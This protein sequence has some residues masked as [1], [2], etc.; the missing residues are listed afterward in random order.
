M[1]NR[2][3]DIPSMDSV[4]ETAAEFLRAQEVKTPASIDELR[5]SNESAGA[6]VEQILGSFDRLHGTKEES[7][8]ADEGPTPE[9]Y[10]AWV[11][12]MLDLEAAFLE[13]GD[14]AL[15]RQ[16]IDLAGISDA[17]FANRKDEARRLLQQSS[18]I[19]LR[20]YPSVHRL[21]TLGFAPDRFEAVEKLSVGDLVRQER[22][23]GVS[24]TPR[25]KTI[26]GLLR[27]LDARLPADEQ[28]NIWTLEARPELPSSIVISDP[29]RSGDEEL[30]AYWRQRIATYREIHSNEGPTILSI[31]G[32][33]TTAVLWEL[34]NIAEHASDD[35][36]K[37]AA[38]AIAQW[39]EKKR[40]YY[41]DPDPR[42]FE[43]YHLGMEDAGTVMNVLR[44]LD[45]I[46]HF[47]PELFFELIGIDASEGGRSPYFGS[48][49]HKALYNTQRII[50]AANPELGA[51]ALKTMMT[52]LLT[53][54][55]RVQT[56]AAVVSQE[57]LRAM[58]GEMKK[59]VDASPSPQAK[60]QMLMMMAVPFS[61]MAI[62]AEVR[63]QLEA[64]REVSPENMVEELR[65][66][67]DDIEHP[68]KL[69]E[70][71]KGLPKHAT[72]NV[73]VRR[74]LRKI[75]SEEQIESG[76]FR[77][78]TTFEYSHSASG[79]YTFDSPSI[80]PELYKRI[81][82]IDETRDDLGF[83]LRVRVAIRDALSLASVTD[84]F[85]IEETSEKTRARQ[86][87]K[88]VMPDNLYRVDFEAVKH[89]FG[90][91]DQRVAGRFN[92]A[93]RV[94]EGNYGEGVKPTEFYTRSTW[95]EEDVAFFIGQAIIVWKNNAGDRRDDFPG[96]LLKTAKEH[97]P[98]LVF[99]SVIAHPQGKEV[100]FKYFDKFCEMIPAERMYEILVKGDIKPITA[101]RNLFERPGTTSSSAYRK[102][103]QNKID[104]PGKTIGGL[105]VLPDDIIRVTLEPEDIPIL[106]KINRV[107][108]EGKTPW[109][110]HY[111]YNPNVP[112]KDLG[113]VEKRMDL[114][115]IAHKLEEQMKNA[116]L[117]IGEVRNP[118]V[119]PPSEE[120]LSAMRACFDKI[121]Q[122]DPHV[123][124]SK[125]D[126]QRFLDLAFEYFF[127]YPNTQDQKKT[128]LQNVMNNIWQS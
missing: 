6:A 33:K 8:D 38:Q 91:L 84:E 5:Q 18:N 2:I 7:D 100:A 39:L 58:A 52:Q 69:A 111:D 80:L 85:L 116:D 115:S 35:V 97:R 27:Y 3:V 19:A 120:T 43:L 59:S 87:L 95:S 21:V 93:P 102:Y 53:V 44:S 37:N 32:E 114:F 61:R 83:A 119:D 73:A 57:S 10:D 113:T 75:L 108:V 81:P 41:Q 28:T 70:Y 9:S 40:I 20:L 122:Y 90:A 109:E 29:F 79:V 68:L 107:L 42:D 60:A 105:S 65:R 117:S 51:M 64:M 76:V 86:F 124:C 50:N 62:D 34:E 106:I 121:K 125:F 12:A 13:D 63:R 110:I 67:I 17:A 14:G 104:R 11:D 112:I 123:M 30:S 16:L 103:L 45:V 74:E 118:D 4:D 77:S 48:F 66:R 24:L 127:K 98:D 23:H 126:R 56:Y 36:L 31:S 82:L 78:V 96:E 54:D 49:L 92:Y 72:D 15:G 46:K 25:R 55:D 1:A 71:L 128:I 47:D 101:F 22:V 99:L 89:N 88:F 26:I 94:L